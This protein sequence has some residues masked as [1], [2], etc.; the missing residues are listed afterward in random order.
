MAGLTYAWLGDHAKFNGVTAQEAGEYLERLY[1]KYHGH[2]T[3]EEILA[4][5]RNRLSPLNP[6]FEWD[7]NKAAEKH[8]RRQVAMLVSMLRVKRQ[9]KAT[10]TRAFVFVSNP[11]HKGR[12]VYIDIQSAMRNSEMKR[13]VVEKALNGL[14]RWMTAYG[15]AREL[16]FVASRV[17]GL[18]KR[19]EAETLANAGV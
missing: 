3:K 5:S 18:R 14:N 17:E 6:F 19:I 10:T 8:R 15:G 9:R 1:E 16:R 7:E 4:D 12:K 13:E 11:E 2:L